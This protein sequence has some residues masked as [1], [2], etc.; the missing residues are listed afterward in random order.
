MKAG[1]IPIAGLLLLGL[2]PSAAA[3]PAGSEPVHVAIPGGLRGM[4]CYECHIRGTGII[5]PSQERPRK[6]SIASAWESYLKS[7]HGRYRT[8]GDKNA[9]TCEDCHLTREWSNI[10]PLEHP[11]SP[12]N[13]ANL[14]ATCAK[15]HGAS[16]LSS[17]VS[18]GSM[19]LEIRLESLLPGKPLEMRYGFMP[20][21]MKA[22]RAYYIGGFNVAALSLFF[23]LALVFGSL[24]LLSTYMV[25]DLLRQLRER[26]PRKSEEE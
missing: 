22:E 16:M 19:H 13:P 20:G 17:K 12:V 3:G 7:P 23:F 10:L 1:L 21:I 11:D 14:P 5:L 18:Q 25:L 15:C 6:Y 2:L 8:L 4:S 24:T 26:N 9:P